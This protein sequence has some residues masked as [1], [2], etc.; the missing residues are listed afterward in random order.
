MKLQIRDD[1]MLQGFPGRTILCSPDWRE[2]HATV[3]FD[4]NSGDYWIVSPLA[5]EIVRLSTNADLQS[6]EA[7]V[8]H[9]VAHGDE[10]G[11]FDGSATTIRRV[12]NELVQL[13]ILAHT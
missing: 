4:G 3:L 1:A 9:I 5:R 12:I 11:D 8:A 6:V 7:L 13:S 10:I 2:D